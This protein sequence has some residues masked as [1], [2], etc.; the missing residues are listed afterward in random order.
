MQ[1]ILCLDSDYPFRSP[2]VK[3]YDTFWSD[4]DKV[5]ILNDNVK[6]KNHII[7]YS[8]MQFLLLYHTGPTHY[9]YITV[10]NIC[11]KC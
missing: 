1:L 3:S 8:I 6:V 9:V 10:F 11:P 7:Y 5:N 2:W 4:I